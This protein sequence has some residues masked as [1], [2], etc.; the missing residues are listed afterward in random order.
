[1]PFI[2][3][4]VTITHTHT[5]TKGG[6]GGERERERERER[7]KQEKKRQGQSFQVANDVRPF[8]FPARVYTLLRA[9]KLVCQKEEG[10]REVRAYT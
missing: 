6:G 10:G 3:N 4:D 8:A 9:S 2:R 1:M 7:E 5:H